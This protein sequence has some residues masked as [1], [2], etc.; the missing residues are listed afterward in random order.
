[1]LNARDPYLEDRRKLDLAW[2]LLR[3]GARTQTISRWTGLSARRVRALLKRYRARLAELQ[4]RRP[5]GDSPFNMELLMRS[6]LRRLEA[7][8]FATIHQELFV[9]AG[10]QTKAYRSDLGT[11]ELVCEAYE[12]FREKQRQSGLSI[13]QAFLVLSAVRRD[14]EFWL[15]RCPS[16]ETPVLIDRL[17]VAPRRCG[18]CSATINLSDHPAKV[19]S[20]R[21]TSLPGSQ[22]R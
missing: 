4:I 14:T 7:A 13:E 2:R 22:I 8:L 6:P 15:G 17:A 19:E 12:A 1:M 3:H 16:C 21:P 10:L 5:R 18:H 11:A 9:Q 20:E